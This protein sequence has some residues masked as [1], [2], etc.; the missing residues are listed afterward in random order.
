MKFNSDTLYTY[1]DKII[2][3]LQGAT[4]LAQLE[5]AHTMYLNHHR[6]VKDTI[7][8]I[9]S[10]NKMIVN[11]YSKRQKDMKSVC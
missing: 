8:F 3:N 1:Y 10:K 9:R 11:I 4:C 7:H 6:L 2:D 5:V